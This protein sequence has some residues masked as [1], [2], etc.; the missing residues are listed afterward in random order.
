MAVNYTERGKFE[1]TIELEAPFDEWYDGE[2][3]GYAWRRHFEEVI[4]RQVLTAVAAALRS[5]PGWQV[6]PVSRGFPPERRADFVLRFLEGTE[7][8][9]LVKPV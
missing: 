5:Q 3:D 8:E 7:P 4:R 1:I 9:A 2:M 6:T